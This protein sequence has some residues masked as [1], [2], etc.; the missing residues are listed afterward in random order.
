[1]RVSTSCYDPAAMNIP[2]T[3]SFM[4]GMPDAKHGGPRYGPEKQPRPGRWFDPGDH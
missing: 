3:K 4:E 2:L 1:M